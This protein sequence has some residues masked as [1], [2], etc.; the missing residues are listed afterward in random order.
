MSVFDLRG[1]FRLHHSNGATVFLHIDQAVP[2]HDFSEAEP[3]KGTAQEGHVVSTDVTGATRGNEFFLVIT[4]NNG[5][6]G[7]YH[8]T[9]NFLRRL[10][11]ACFD[12]SHPTNQA[13]WFIDAEFRRFP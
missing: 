6:V 1:D 13:T 3:L 10:S 12:R 9:F 8:G 4:W 11:G 2:Q 7:E 5:S